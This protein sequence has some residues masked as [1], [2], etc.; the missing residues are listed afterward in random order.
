[1]SDPYSTLE[2]NRVN[3][4]KESQSVKLVG[5]NQPAK[6]LLGRR[7]RYLSGIFKIRA[8]TWLQGKGPGTFNFSHSFIVN[9]PRVRVHYASSKVIKFSADKNG[10]CKLFD[11]WI[12]QI[13]RGRDLKRL[14]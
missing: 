12:I 4:N 9:G 1:M 2:P 6:S 13:S 3:T 10:R 5:I 8:E 11:I 14:F 7:T